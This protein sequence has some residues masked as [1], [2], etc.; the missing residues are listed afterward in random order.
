[1]S[2]FAP[3][4]VKKYNDYATRIDYSNSLI[5]FEEPRL[6]EVQIKSFNRFLE[7]EL[8]NLFKLY[9]PVSHPKNTEYVIEYKGLKFVNPAKS[10]SIKDAIYKQQTYQKSLYVDLALINLKTG[11]VD[12]VEK[13]KD[14]ISSGIFFSTFPTITPKGTF[15]V[16]GV[17]KNILPQIVRSPG[18]YSLSFSRAFDLSKLKVGRKKYAYN[19]FCEI[20]P[21]RGTLMHFFIDRNDNIVFRFRTTTILAKSAKILPVSILLKGLGFDNDEILKIYGNHDLMRRTIDS[22]GFG[23]DVLT[24][25]DLMKF[26]SSVKNN[27]LSFSGANTCLYKLCQEYLK[28]KNSQTII[29]SIISE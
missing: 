23:I 13:P 8:D 3:S 19:A 29:S 27:T 14:G 1:M 12:V 10:P 26:F 15:I 17:E 20:L 2:K 25:K 28:N 21:T 7:K 16:N 5:N 24:N 22:D 11:K 6:L 18:M 9:F 4:K